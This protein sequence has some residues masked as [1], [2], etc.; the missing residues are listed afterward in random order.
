MTAQGALDRSEVDRVFG[1][2]R[3]NVG[4]S[5][6][7]MAMAQRTGFENVGVHR[8]ELELRELVRSILP[9]SSA[10]RHG[11]TCPLHLIV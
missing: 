5:A 9:P 7:G 8:L 6:V 3:I 10:L 11:A 1:E 4:E 2:E